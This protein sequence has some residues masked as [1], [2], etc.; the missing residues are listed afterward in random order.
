MQQVSLEVILQIVFGLSQGERYQR[1]KPLLTEWLDMTDSPLRSS[2]LFL[3]G[4]ISLL[5]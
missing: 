1:L 4:S 5:Q 2:M 3:R